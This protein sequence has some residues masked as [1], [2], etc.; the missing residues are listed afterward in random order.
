MARVFIP[1]LGRLLFQRF[2]GVLLQEGE[3]SHRIILGR[4]LLRGYRLSYDGVSGAVEL[5]DD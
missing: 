2:T 1:E 4:G 5:T 3:Q